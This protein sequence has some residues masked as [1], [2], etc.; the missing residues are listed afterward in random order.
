MSD[1]LTAVVVCPAKYI[2]VLKMVTPKT[3]VIVKYKIF[4]LMII[5]LAIKFLMAKGNRIITATNQRQK[6]RLIGGML[7]LRPRAIIKFPDQMA[8]APKAKK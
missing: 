3:A 4:F 7:S 5:R 6:A 2:K 8:V 1:K